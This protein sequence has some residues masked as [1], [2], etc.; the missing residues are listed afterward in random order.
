MK[1]AKNDAVS[2]SA[3]QHKKQLKN[4]KQLFKDEMV[5]AKVKHDKDVYKLINSAK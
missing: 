5:M 4:T 3:T 2:A 1:K